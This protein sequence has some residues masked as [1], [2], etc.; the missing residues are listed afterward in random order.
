MKARLLVPLLVSALG[1]AREGHVLEREA[2]YPPRVS[3]SDVEQMCSEALLEVKGLQ[4]KMSAKDVDALLIKK[5]GAENAGV[6]I[7][8]IREKH[9][10]V[11]VDELFLPT[12]T[13]CSTR[14]LPKKCQEACDQSFD[15][16]RAK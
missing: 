14:G 7:R 11:R 16:G 12:S 15:I 1:C 6:L 9:A 4:P 5:F 3:V 10:T 2:A 8:S 13:L